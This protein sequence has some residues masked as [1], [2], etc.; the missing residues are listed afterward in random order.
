MAAVTMLVANENGTVTSV[1]STWTDCASIAAGSFTAGRKYLIIA[2]GLIQCQGGASEHHIRLVHGTTPTV[3]PDAE[4]IYDPGIGAAD[5][6]ATWQY[7]TIWTQPG[8]AELVKIQIL[9]EASTANVTSGLTQIQCVDLTDLTENTDYW[10]NE[11]TADYTTTTTPTAQAA[12]TLT[13]NGTDDF[14]VIGNIVDA[15]PANIAD[16]TDFRCQL[17]ESVGAT[18]APLLDWEA[19]D[20][21]VGDEQRA[22]CLQRVWAAPSAASRTWSVRPYHAGG[23]FSV[24]S[25]RIFVLRLNKFDQH[26]IVYTAASDAPTAS[27]TWETEATVSA[28]PNVTGDWFYLASVICTNPGAAK[29]RLQHNNSGSFVSEP[30]YGDDEPVEPPAWDATDQIPQFMGNIRSLTSGASRTINFDLSTLVTT[31]SVQDR[32]IVAFSAELASTGVTVTPT[33]LALTLAT[34]APVIQL[35]VIPD[36]AA[37]ILTTFAP[38]IQLVVVPGVAGLALTVFAPTVSVSDN[39]L[40]T[41]PV[42]ALVTTAFAPTVTAGGSGV[43]TPTTLALVTATFAPTIVLPQLV[44]P[45]VLA[46]VAATFAPTVSASDHQ[47][48][49]PPVLALVTAAFAPTVTAGGAVVVTPTTLALTLATFAPVIQLVVI[50]NTA[51][52]ILTT[53]APVIQLVV[54]PG[55]AGLAL[56]VFAP[57]VSVSGHQLVTPTTLA[58][59]LT[60]FAPTVTAGGAV[61]VTPSLDIAY[62]LREGAAKPLV[63]FKLTRDNR[64]WG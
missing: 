27:P 62:A 53:F 40:L 2:N 16:G 5:G 11:V 46:L 33:T 36:T 43:V 63:D 31:P 18:T 7:M 61:V 35:V 14:W 19:E 41:P 17:F 30:A 24:L 13:P 25:S 9:R 59:L 57:T 32:C 54:I 58:L 3:F 6:R 29:M 39:Q 1:N 60:V 52:L 50:P 22:A 42:L 4:G 44:T 37:L 23:T 64:S 26:A 49:T 20:I 38:V 55:V 48:V 28:T 8:T 21:D 51:A 56:T 34:F 15:L 10:F 12:V 45:T 47:L